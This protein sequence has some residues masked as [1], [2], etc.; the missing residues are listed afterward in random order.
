MFKRKQM[1]DI[2]R[3][4]K[5]HFSC[6]NLS[7]FFFIRKSSFMDSFPLPLKHWFPN[8]SSWSIFLLWEQLIYRLY[9]IVCA[10]GL[11]RC[12]SKINFIP[13]CLRILNWLV[14]RL[15]MCCLIF[16]NSSSD[17]HAAANHRFV[18]MRSFNTLTFL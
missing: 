12:V 8:K 4:Q 7:Y 2:D 11:S 9:I 6:H 14:R 16:H 15:I 18:L 17:S 3:I 13:W 5:Q 10:P 1:T